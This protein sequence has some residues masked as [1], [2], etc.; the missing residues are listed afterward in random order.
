M[1]DSLTVRM[2]K[3]QFETFAEHYPEMEESKQF[4]LFTSFCAIKQYDFDTDFLEDSLTGDGGDGGIDWAHVIVN[5]TVFDNLEEPDL[6]SIPKNSKMKFIFGQAKKET[7]FK[8]KAANALLSTFSD[9]FNESEEK[10][11]RIYNKTF[12]KKMREIKEFWQLAV[13]KRPEL[14]IEINYSTFSDR[15]PHDDT[16]GAFEV[17]ERHLR[18][19]FSNAKVQTLFTGAAELFCISNSLPSYD[20]DLKYHVELDSSSGKVAL[21]NLSDYFNFLTDEEGQLNQHFFEDNVRDFEGKV[22][23]NENIISTLQSDS[24]SPDFWWLNNGI[25]ILVSDSPISRA[26]TY[27]LRDVQIVNGLQTSRCIFDYFSEHAE[28]L[29]SDSRSVLVRI[30]SPSE[31]PEKDRI[32][33][34]TNSQTT[35]SVASLRATDPVHREIEGALKLNAI[36]YDRRKN[37]WKNQGVSPM[38]IIS[39]V[40]LSQAVISAFLH[41]PNTARA[42]PSSFLKTDSTYDEIFNG[43]PLEDFVWAAINLKNVERILFQHLPGEPG[44]RNNLKFYILMTCRV[45]GHCV[46]VREQRWQ[47]ANCPSDYLPSDAVIISLTNWVSEQ[48]KELA[49]EQNDSLDKICKGSELTSKIANE[50][51]NCAPIEELLK[52]CL[53]A[54]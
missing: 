17:L 51:E 2:A 3:Q 54:E 48:A 47:S 5:D 22:E 20:S 19:I 45:L 24:A 27:S 7:G 23:V 25:T 26:K 39:V 15:A 30:L 53:E 49:A 44:L 16:R 32:I 1:P 8:A 34:A 6:S 4:E 46:S 41:K 50:W 29:K 35:V 9:L 37:Y 40:A 13:T 52:S 43:R 10:P 11:S 18:G 14:E 36:Y 28:K 12:A 31:A 33:R 21:V 42:R 38:K